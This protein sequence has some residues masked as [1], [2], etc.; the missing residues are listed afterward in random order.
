VGENETAGEVHD[1][2]MTIGAALVLKTV[3]AIEEGNY[4]QTDQADFI[5][6][7]E[8][9]KHAPKI[10]KEDCRINWDHSLDEIHNMVRGLSPY[11]AAFTD[12]ISEDQKVFALK[13]FKTEKEKTAHSYPVRSIH[14][15]SKTYMKVAVKGGFLTITE[16]QLAGK[17]RMSVHEFLRG[18]QINNSWKVL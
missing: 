15:D 8:K 12:L 5:A 11:P 4:P 17:K 2:L 1:R 14:T 3:K 16:L 13:I 10:F 6:K 9:E 7:G 18:F